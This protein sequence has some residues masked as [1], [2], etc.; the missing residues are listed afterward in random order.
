MKLMLFCYC[1]LGVLLKVIV[2]GCFNVIFVMFFLNIFIIIYID[3]I[4]VMLII[5]VFGFIK[6]FLWILRCLIMFDLGV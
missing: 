2:I 3:L 5:V 1:W 4:G 6:K